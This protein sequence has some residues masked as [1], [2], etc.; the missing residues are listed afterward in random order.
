MDLEA[1]FQY[2]HADKPQTKVLN[3]SRWIHPQCRSYLTEKQVQKYIIGFSLY[4]IKM[5]FKDFL[6]TF[7]EFFHKIQNLVEPEISFLNQIKAA[8]N[9]L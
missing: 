5:K 4:N 2:C 1:Y 3:V 9:F 8:W 6:G 7:R